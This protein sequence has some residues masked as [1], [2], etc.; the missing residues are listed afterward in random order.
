MLSMQH[1]GFSRV[2]KPKILTTA[3]SGRLLEPRLHHE[4]RALSGLAVYQ[5]TFSVLWKH[6]HISSQQHICSKGLRSKLV[7]F[8]ATTVLHQLEQKPHA[9]VSNG[10]MHCIQAEDL[11]HLLQCRTCIL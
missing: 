9:F 1:G 11:L 4:F 2:C 5:I 10:Y 3:C 6:V 8:T 7:L